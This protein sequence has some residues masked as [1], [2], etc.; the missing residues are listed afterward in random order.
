MVT[1]LILRTRLKRR[2][3][4]GVVSAVEDERLNEAINSGL[5]RALSDGVPG[6]SYS[7]FTG[8]PLATVAVTGAVTELSATLA[9]TGGADMNVQK[10][11]PH[12]FLTFDTDGSQF[13]IKDVLTASS[14]SIGI[15]AN[16]TISAEAATITRRSL[17]LPSTGQVSA[18]Y[19][20]GS[21]DALA[22]EPSIAH[23]DPFKTG[24]PRYYEQRYSEGQSA[25]FIS[26]WPAPSDTTKQFI[27][28]QAQFKT[29]LTSDSDTLG[30]PEEVLDAILERARDCHLTWGGSANQNDLTASYRALRDTSDSLKNSSSTKQ[31]FLKT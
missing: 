29:Q 23:R 25:S 22:R 28:Q 19:P 9:I 4:L 7:M 10:V 6:L 15:P 5:A 21:R 20:V 2:L 18:V 30:F 16:A 12:D 8:S 14:L 24:T 13:L 31:I 1:R 3:G 26:L 11:M 17:L 27:I